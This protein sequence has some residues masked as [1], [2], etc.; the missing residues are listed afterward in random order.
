MNLQKF[1]QKSIEAVQQ[2]Q[3]LAAEY[4]NQQ[5]E[6]AHLLLALAQAP[7]MAGHFVRSTGLEESFLEPVVTGKRARSH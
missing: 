4:G 2:T 3:S 1:T 6:Q 5:L 7:G